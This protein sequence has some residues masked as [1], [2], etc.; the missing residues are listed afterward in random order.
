M[1]ETRSPKRSIPRGVTANGQSDTAMN[2]TID[3]ILKR[4]ENYSELNQRER[5]SVQ[6]DLITFS[7]RQP[8][9]FIV[10]IRKIEPSEESVLFEIYESLSSQPDKWI[11][12]LISEF[13]RIEKHTIQ[14]K[15]K[16]KDSVSSPLI[17]LSFF[18]RQGFANNDKLIAR[19]K[20]GVASESKQIA[21][22]SLD[23]LADVYLIDKS[24]YG[25]CRQVIERQTQSKTI[26][27]SQ[28]AKE[29]LN[30][31]DNP[32]QPKKKLRLYSAYSFIFFVG[33]L[34]LSAISI[35]LYNKTFIG[36]SAIAVTFC[37]TGLLSWILHQILT[38]KVDVKKSET[39]AIGLAYGFISCFLILYINLQSSD[40][41]YRHERYTIIDHGTL[42]KGRYSDCRKP[43]IKF[44][45]KGEIK[46][47][48]FSCE[49]HEI[50]ENAT[51]IKLTI[52]KGLLDFDIVIDK[53]LE[54]TGANI[55]YK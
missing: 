28:L 12:F 18:A 34:Y 27:I 46:K 21:K 29:I 4:L 44:E 54:T 20:K 43:Y 3:N 11:D 51:Q 5:K 53:R 37:V 13:D 9:N 6:N 22:I 19:I 52:Q 49:D 35:A 7:E 31:L 50:V 38:R 14:A 2:E 15:S 1:N 41:N 40:S 24:K 26:E 30:D 47:M 45:R 39:L 32:V 55:L 33:G 25:S 36:F 8:D 16:I 10:F 48:T 23:L 17:A 42:A